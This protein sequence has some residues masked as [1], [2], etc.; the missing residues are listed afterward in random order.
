MFDISGSGRNVDPQV[1]DVRLVL[2]GAPATTIGGGNGTQPGGPEG[3]LTIL[4]R[5]PARNLPPF[6][7]EHQGSNGEAGLAWTVSDVL[8]LNWALVGRAALRT[9]EDEHQR[10]WGNKSYK[11]WRVH[12]VDGTNPDASEAGVPWLDYVRLMLSLPIAGCPWAFDL[13]LHQIPTSLA[14]VVIPG[15]KRNE[16]VLVAQQLG[17]L[18]Q[19]FDE[20]NIPNEHDPERPD[21]VDADKRL[22]ERSHGIIQYVTQRCSGLVICAP[23]VTLPGEQPVEDPDSPG[24]SSGKYRRWVLAGEMWKYWNYALF[25]VLHERRQLG[26]IL[27][28]LSDLE[29]PVRTSATPLDQRQEEL[30]VAIARLSTAEQT[31]YQLQASFRYRVISRKYGLQNYYEHCYAELRLEA[32]YNDVEQILTG[33][34][35]VVQRQMES[36]SNELEEERNRIAR[37]DAERETRFERMVSGGGVLFGVVALVFGVLS[38]NIRDWTSNEG[39]APQWAIVAVG[40]AVLLGVVALAI[41]RRLFKRGEQRLGTLDAGA[42]ARHLP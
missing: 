14:S 13:D 4:L 2:T 37:A 35:R 26:R 38:I 31:F 5:V 28:E 12:P 40:I 22:M 11:A 25:L 20:T 30:D 19:N 10:L 29:I 8:Q 24:P 17:E 39:L 21:P 18:L 9:V 27:D 15:A 23:P 3:Y 6:G 33:I 32:L 34:D 7:D 16:A 1:C 41:L 42:S 36:V